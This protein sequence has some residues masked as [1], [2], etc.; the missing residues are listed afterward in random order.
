MDTYFAICGAVVMLVVVMALIAVQPLVLLWALNTLGWVVP[1][2]GWTY[3]AGL[4]CMWAL[5]G[6]RL[7][8]SRKDS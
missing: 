4:V 6:I 7:G 2:T 8:S 1:Y 5:G 3:L